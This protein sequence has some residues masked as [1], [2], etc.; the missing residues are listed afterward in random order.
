MSFD[1]P[2]YVLFLAMMALA[3][4]YCPAKGRWVLLLAGSLFFYACWSAPLTL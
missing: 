4:R 2:R 1:T 3:H